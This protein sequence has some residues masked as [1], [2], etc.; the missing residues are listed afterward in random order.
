[1][2]QRE[3]DALPG[4]IEAL[5]REQHALAVAMAVPDY[6]K[7]GAERIKADRERTVA[8]EQLLETKFE[9]WAALEDKAKQ[10]AAG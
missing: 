8:I 6:H 3:L 4:E 10:A 9:R 5:E 7:L 1:M 2:E